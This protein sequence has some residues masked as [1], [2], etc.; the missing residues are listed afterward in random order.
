MKNKAAITVYPEGEEEHGGFTGGITAIREARRGMINLSNASAYLSVSQLTRLLVVLLG[1]MTELPMLSPA[2]ILVG[3]LIFDFGITLVM[4][5]EKA[6]REVF[7]IPCVPLPDYAEGHKTMIGFGLSAGF[8][9]ALLPSLVNGLAP[10]FH[11]HALRT[12]EALSVVTAAL[13]LTQTAIGTQFMRRG[14]LLRQGS[15]LNSAY[16]CCLGTCVV[17]SMLL[18]FENHTSAFIDGRPAPWYGAIFALLPPL[19]LFFI[20]EF[21][22]N[23]RK[24]GEKKRK[25]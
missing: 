2:A 8:L 19:I 10:I 11:V 15:G 7:A 3:G 4:A 24:P 14:P 9:I 16:L 23:R 12:S 17:F 1:V 13:F 5:F 20:M 25:K 22:K 18:L 6:P 21:R